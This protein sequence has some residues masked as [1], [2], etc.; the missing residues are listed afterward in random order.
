MKWMVASLV[1]FLH[2]S[3]RGLHIM[4]LRGTFPELTWL[5]TYYRL[6]AWWPG[7]GVH[8]RKTLLNPR[9]EDFDYEVMPEI[10][11]NMLGWMGNGMTVAQRDK[12]FTSEYLDLKQVLNKP[13]PVNPNISTNSPRQPPPKGV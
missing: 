3:T 11:E 2:H 7:S 10:E 1:S 12:G 8:S 13:K 4:Q 9:W 5:M 6:I